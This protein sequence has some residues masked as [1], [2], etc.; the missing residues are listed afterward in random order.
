L[1]DKQ[2]HRVTSFSTMNLFATQ[3]NTLGAI[4]RWAKAEL[5]DLP[6]A[7][8]SDILLVVTELVTNAYEHGGGPRRVRL[9]RHEEPLLVTVEVDDTSA[10][11]PTVGPEHHRGRGLVLVAKLAADWGVTPHAGGKTVWARFS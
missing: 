2:H 4:R 3:P 6:R 7:V 8:V 5:A 10:G 1:A 11:A 9:T